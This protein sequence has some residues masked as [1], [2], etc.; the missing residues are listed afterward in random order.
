MNNQADSNPIATRTFSTRP[1]LRSFVDGKMRVDKNVAIEVEDGRIVMADVYRPDTTQRYPAVMCFTPYGKDIHF[2]TKEPAVYARISMK[3]EYAVYEAP[4]ILRWVADDYAVVIV[5]ACGLGASPGVADVWSP[6]DIE[7]YAAAIEAIAVQPWCTGRVGLNGISYLSATQ[8]AVATHKPPHLT[9]MIPWEVGGDNYEMTYQEG[10]FNT[11]FVN[12]WFDAWIVPN[13]HGYGTLPPHELERMREN[14]P[15]KAIAHPF[16]DE[17][18]A[19]RTPD[20]SVIDVP[21]LT[22][23]NWTGSLLSLQQHFDLF[24]Q[25]ASK[26]KWLRAHIGGH[27]EPYYSEEGYA[28]QKKF[29]DFWLKDIQNGMMETSPLTLCVRRPGAIEWMEAREW[30]LPQT[31]WVKWQLDAEAMSLSSDPVQGSA[32]ADL[33]AVPIEPPRLEKP[34]EDNSEHHAVHMNE[35]VMQAYIKDGLSR[36]LQQSWNAVFT[37]KP[38]E[39]DLRLVG[40]VTVHLTVTASEGDADLFVCLRDIAP[41]GTEVVYD[42]LDNPETPLGL[43]WG[44]LS[45]RELDPDRMIDGSHRPVHRRDCEKAPAPGET[46]TIDIAVGPTSAVFEKGHRLIIE[47]STRDVF[48]SFPFFHVTPE[49]QRIGGEVKIKTGKGASWVEL[50]VCP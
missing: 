21:F 17:F 46:V 34:A 27:I 10:M 39:D 24:C 41:D 20:L 26:H 50:P 43:G 16:F 48:R 40:P 7:D 1:P 25:A 35:S 6:R 44:R 5:D 42:G 22:A 3:N 30:P 14:W 13:Q 29:M 32:T 2:E 31:Q 19:A 37:S 11:F 49:H 36:P 15:A 28:A 38:L 23:A 18:W 33:L 12:S 9:C 47:V 45:R 4:D 8:I